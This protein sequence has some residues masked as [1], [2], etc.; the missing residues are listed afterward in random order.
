MDQTHLESFFSEM[1]LQAQPSMI[2]K[3]LELTRD[4]SIIS[5]AGGLP[6]P[7][8]FPS[9]QLIEITREILTR[10]PEKALQYTITGGYPPFVDEIIVE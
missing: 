10:N 2:R 9:E 3:I 4:D 7:K 5:F 8:T 6:N 1:A